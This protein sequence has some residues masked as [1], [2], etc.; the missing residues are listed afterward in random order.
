MPK[1]DN[2]L[3]VLGEAPFRQKGLTIAAPVLPV[4]VSESCVCLRQPMGGDVAN[5]VRKGGRV[6]PVDSSR[7]GL[8]KL[9]AAVWVACGWVPAVEGSRWNEESTEN[10][11]EK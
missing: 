3:Q 2:Y 4:K 7:Q 8:L 6:V 10:R 5:G 9:G 11:G 1:Q